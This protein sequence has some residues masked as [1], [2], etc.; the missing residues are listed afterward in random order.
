MLW[1]VILAVVVALVAAVAGVFAI[2]RAYAVLPKPT[3]FAEG[4]RLIFGW[5]AAGAGIFCGLMAIAMIVLL[6]WGGWGKEEEHTI[7]IIF[8]WSLGGFISAMVVV[9]VGLLVGG[10]VGRFSGG[11]TK[12]GLSFEA[13]KDEHQSVTVATTVETSGQGGSNTSNTSTSTST[14]KPPSDDVL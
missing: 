6:T 8:G 4:Q 5:L 10:P 9:L 2:R 3:T 12:G 7:V 14:T 11:I 1:W 13:G